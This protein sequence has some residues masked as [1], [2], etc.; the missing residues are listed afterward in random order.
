M[1]KRWKEVKRGTYETV[2][3]GLDGVFVLADSST[4]VTIEDK[5][6]YCCGRGNLLVRAS[7]GLKMGVRGEEMEREA[8]RRTLTLGS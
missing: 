5:K 2:R 1:N 6:T 3:L 7:R 8:A 4:R